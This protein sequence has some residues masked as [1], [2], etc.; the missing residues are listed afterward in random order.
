MTII[1][2]LAASQPVLGF[3]VPGIRETVSDGKDGLL[4]PT[5]PEALGERMARIATDAE[6]R[7]RLSDGARRSAQQYNIETT[8]R[9]I[10]D[11]YERVIRERKHMAAYR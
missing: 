7:A 9:R 10:V 2:A 4:A 5:D 6:L 8:T 11:H 1:E 3:N